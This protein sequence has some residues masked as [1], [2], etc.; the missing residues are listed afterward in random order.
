[1]E[2]VTAGFEPTIDVVPG[3]E[4]PALGVVTDALDRGRQLWMR[5]YTA[6]RDAVSER[7]VDPIRLI[8][9]DGHTYLEAYCHLVSAVRQFRVDRIEDARVTEAPAQPPLWVDDE[10]PDRM[11]HPDPHRP[12]DTLVLH[13]EARWIAEYY[14]V[15]EIVELP[16]DDA[17]PSGFLMVRM[18]TPGGDWLV[19]LL[20]SLGGDAQI[21]DREELTA[22]VVERATAALEL[23]RERQPA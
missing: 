4:A 21:V 13:P 2:A 3:D 6:S 18:R 20:L 7:T 5:Y 16:D 9:T 23:Y 11:Y 14:S 19:R 10:V 1:L 15:D 8:L 22:R 12:V 17:G